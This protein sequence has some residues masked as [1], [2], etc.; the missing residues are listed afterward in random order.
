MLSAVTSMLSPTISMLSCIC[1]QA[2]QEAD[3]RL[4]QTLENHRGNIT[5]AEVRDLLDQHQQDVD[6]LRKRHR[7][8]AAASDHKLRE[9]LLLRI[10]K[11]NGQVNYIFTH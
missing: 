3:S 10:Q 9:K 6:R 5:E 8:A 11:R 7:I 2:V 4:T 1:P